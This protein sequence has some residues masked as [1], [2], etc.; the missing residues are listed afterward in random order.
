MIGSDIRNID[1]ESLKL[2][3]NKDLIA[4]NQD[5]AFNRPWLIQCSDDII[6]SPEICCYGRSHRS[7]EF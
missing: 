6:D 5:K 1:E 3:S 7:A 2:L 4:I